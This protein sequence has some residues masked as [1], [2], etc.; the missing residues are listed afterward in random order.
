MT[1]LT[2]GTALFNFLKSNKKQILKCGQRKIKIPI[3]KR[4]CQIASASC[5]LSVSRWCHGFSGKYDIIGK[6]EINVTCAAAN[7]STGE[8]R[9][10]SVPPAVVSFLHL[11]S[12]DSGSRRWTPPIKFELISHSGAVHSCHKDGDFLIQKSPI[13]PSGLWLFQ[14]CGFCNWWI[15]SWCLFSGKKIILKLW[16]LPRTMRLSWVGLGVGLALW[17]WPACIHMHVSY[18]T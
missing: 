6:K 7:W 11:V 10:A 4:F 12:C 3:W 1:A 2:A 15:S 17:S 14:F 5:C 16:M 8:E 13:C 18:T 9:Q